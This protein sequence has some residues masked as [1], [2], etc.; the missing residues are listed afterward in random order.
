MNTCR[1]I[2]F[3]T[4]LLFLMGCSVSNNNEP[5]W[6]EYKFNDFGI[7]LEAPY[8]LVADR[9][10][11]DDGEKTLSISTKI[12]VA[13]SLLYAI[14]NL[15]FAAPWRGRNQLGLLNVNFVA[16]SLGSQGNDYDRQKLIDDYLS[17]LKLE[18]LTADSVEY[19]INSIQCSGLPAVLVT[20]Q[21]K[22]EL[23][24]SGI[25]D[26]T[27]ISTIFISKKSNTGK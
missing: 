2:L 26:I 15:K 17:I 8:P 10:Q 9:Q 20:I 7:S 16:H 12:S 21:V 25:F 23:K 27:S 18:K 4:P 6:K 14:R 22:H 5:N 24:T 3:L 19:K 11:K 13:D 1:R